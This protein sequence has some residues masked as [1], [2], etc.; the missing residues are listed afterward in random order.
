MALAAEG[1]IVALVDGRTEALAA[2]GFAESLVALGFADIFDADG[3]AD[4]F[5][6]GLVDTLAAVVSKVETLSSISWEG[7]MK[8]ISDSCESIAAG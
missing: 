7:L 5:A 4:G 8:D 2:E 3:F 6:D 1:F